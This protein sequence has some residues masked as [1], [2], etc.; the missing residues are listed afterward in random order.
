MILSQVRAYSSINEKINKDFQAERKNKK[1]ILEATREKIE[2]YKGDLA[3][4]ISRSNCYKSRSET[5]E[6][7]LKEL[8]VKC[9]KIDEHTKLLQLDIEKKSEEIERLQN[10]LVKTDEKNKNVSFIY[11]M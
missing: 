4:A 7:K 3:K 10:E 5:A 2:L 9:Q 8:M 6:K 1:D 11:F